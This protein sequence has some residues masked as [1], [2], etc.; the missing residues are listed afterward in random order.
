[1]IE[2]HDEDLRTNSQNF[3]LIG[4]SND[5]A[6]NQKETA[7]HMK[8][9]GN[10]LNSSNSANGKTT[11]SKDFRNQSI[12]SQYS[13][14]PGVLNEAF[15]NNEG[16]SSSASNGDYDNNLEHAFEENLWEMLG[17]NV[18]NDGDGD[19]DDGGDDDDDDLEMEIM[20]INELANMNDLNFEDDMFHGDQFQE[21]FGQTQFDR[22][23]S[24][25]DDAAADGGGG[26]AENLCN[27]FNLMS[28]DLME[29]S[30]EL[31]GQMVNSFDQ[32]FNNFDQNLQAEQQ[33]IEQEIVE[34]QNLQNDLQNDNECNAE[35]YCDDV[36]GTELIGVD[37]LDYNNGMDKI[38]S[39]SIDGDPTG[40]DGINALDYFGDAPILLDQQV[41]IEGFDNFLDQ[42]NIED[43]ENDDVFDKNLEFE[44]LE[45][46]REVD[47]LEELEDLE[48]DIEND[49]D[50]DEFDH[51]NFVGGHE[52]FENDQLPIIADEDATGDGNGDVTEEA[53][54][55]VATNSFDNEIEA[56]DMNNVNNNNDNA[57]DDGNNAENSMDEIAFAA[58]VED[59]D[60]EEDDDGDGSGGGSNEDNL[61]GFGFGVGAND[62]DLDRQGGNEAMS[63]A[64]EEGSGGGS[65]SGDL[66][67]DHDPGDNDLCNVELN[68][69]DNENG[70]GI[71]EGGGDGVNN[72]NLVDNKE[73]NEALIAGLDPFL[74]QD[75]NNDN[76]GDED[77]G[78]GGA[79]NINEDIEFNASHL[80]QVQM[81]MES[82]E[83]AAR[84]SIAG[85]NNIPD[86][87]NKNNEKESEND[88]EDGGDDNIDDALMNEAASALDF[89]DREL[90]ALLQQAEQEFDNQE[91][92]V[93]DGKTN[94]AVSSSKNAG[95]SRG[96]GFSMGKVQALGTLLA[97]GR[98][99]LRNLG[100]P[101]QDS[102]H[103]NQRRVSDY[104]HNQNFGQARV[105]NPATLAD[106]SQVTTSKVKEQYPGDSNQPSHGT[107]KSTNNIK[108]PVKIKNQN[109]K[110]KKEGNSDSSDD[111]QNFQDDVDYDL[112][113]S[114]FSLGTI[115]EQAD[116]DEPS[117]IEE[118]FSSDDKRSP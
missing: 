58:E 96:S 46:L 109:Y 62:V 2:E 81:L 51:E 74:C 113:E 90:E 105:N 45:F 53:T 102:I 64:E 66:N 32:D 56:G 54:N 98:S 100:L 35:N 49:E 117:S 37:L 6:R 33:E 80:F 84:D 18:E 21:S 19:N 83:M 14:N 7:S 91:T 59:D 48:N 65:G 99:S 39:Q 86:D 116:D 38:G 71:G 111:Q 5:G 72:Q 36:L 77:S 31:A 106:F 4:Q 20:L 55:T 115:E 92:G 60:D 28:L 85:F 1:M 11:S 41:E 43:L 114:E 24:A 40:Y 8:N 73:M 10:R 103:N 69:A 9:T 57:S 89:L 34:M 16:G 25:R 42:A 17:N 52:D 13:V 68:D 29:L 26:D 87:K 30:Q 108:N 3:L 104:F 61:D 27:Q 112:C 93:E 101:T 22:H 23:M 94:D 79:D 50:W 97:G 70:G 110:S 12:I 15:E 78:G 67:N 63:G 107:I 44:E 82:A 88:N 75:Q 118:D 76:D 95:V 47:Q